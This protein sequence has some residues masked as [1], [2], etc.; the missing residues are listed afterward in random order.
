MNVSMRLTMLCCQTTISL[1]IQFKLI[2]TCTEI[3]GTVWT[4]IHSAFNEQVT[5]PQD[6][7]KQFSAAG[8]PWL[9]HFRVQWY[10]GKNFGSRL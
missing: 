7:R 9:K 10:V 5:A 6:A 8:F 1:F 3:S 4:T 2:R